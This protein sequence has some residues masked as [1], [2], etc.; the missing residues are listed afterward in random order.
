MKIACGT[1]LFRQH[2]LEKAMDAIREIGYEYVETQAVGP[3]CP[4][5]TIGKS[6][7]I[8][9][10]DMVKSRGF[11]GTTAL[12]MP[13]GTIL[14]DERCVEYGI[15]TLEWAQAA[16]IP[17]INTGDGYKPADMSDEEAFAVYEERMGKLLEAAERCKVGI[18]M[19]PHGTFSLTGKGLQRLLAF[20]DSP[21]LGVNYDACNI[22]RAGYIESHGDEGDITKVASTKLGLEDE[23]GVLETIVSRVLHVHAKDYHIDH[24]MPLGEGDVRVAECL[25]VLKKADYTGAVS[26]ETEGDEDFDVSVEY[27]K[28][29]FAFLKQHL[30]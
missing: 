13:Y 1:V 16:G 29:S 8:Q 20:S 25:Q 27:A 7:P 6:D 9:Y 3:W 23:V 10:A 5:I 21:W 11:K 2:P 22:Y 18:A 15:R 12:W 26:L 30:E 17:V 28:K 24:C 19:E 14:S 4:H